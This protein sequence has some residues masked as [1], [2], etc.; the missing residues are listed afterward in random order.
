M[1]GILDRWRQLGRRFFWP[2]LL[3]GMVAASLGLPTLSSSAQTAAAPETSASSNGPVPSCLQN[4][5]FLPEN[6][7]RSSFSIDYWHQ[8]AIRTVI[9]HLSFAVSQPELHDAAPLRIQQGVL[10]SR[11]SA[12]LTLEGKPPVII[13]YLQQT[14]AQIIYTFK[15]AAWLGQI[16]GIR[17]GP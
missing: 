6:S 8:H 14:T 1:T 5:V 12:L 7:R 16:Q 2:H 3:F 9:R 15:V 10:L 13:R 4:L 11:L 17:A